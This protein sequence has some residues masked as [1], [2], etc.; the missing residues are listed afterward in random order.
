MP[1]SDQPTVLLEGI[2]IIFRNFEGKEGP[3][4]SAGSRTFA[5][6]LPDDKIAEVMATDGWNVKWLKPREDEEDEKPQPYLPVAIR[7]DVFPPRVVLVTSRGRT[8]LDDN[9]IAMLDWANIINVDL[10]VRGYPWEVNEK[11]GL[12]AYVQSLYVTIEE[13]ALEMKYSE[14]EAP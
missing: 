9:S 7:F 6:L 3:Y 1:A 12:K 8:N 11:K 13:D 2:R 4:N 10:I 14:V 5:V